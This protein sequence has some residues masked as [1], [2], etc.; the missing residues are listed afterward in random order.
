[1]LARGAISRRL[2]IPLSPRRSAGL[3]VVQREDREDDLR[4]HVRRGA[5]ERAFEGRLDVL[6]LTDEER[7]IAEV[8]RDDG[9]DV[10][11]R[12]HGARRGA[13][14]AIA[15]WGA[16]A[17][18]MLFELER[19]P[20][21]PWARKTTNRILFMDNFWRSNHTPGLYEGFAGH[22][23]TLLLSLGSVALRRSKRRQK[24]AVFHDG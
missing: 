18:L 7:R 3:I 23:R 4:R 8:D 5:R 15:P 11:V 1:M 6:I 13:N 14:T 17:N 19:D 24:G 16:D 21:C 20:P 9:A 12:F 10:G 22:F 2:L